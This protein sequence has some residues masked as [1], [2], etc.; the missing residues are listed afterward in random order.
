LWVAL[1]ITTVQLADGVVEITPRG[2]IDAGNANEVRDAVDAALA[3]YHPGQVQLNL[4]LVTLLDSAGIGA[5]VASHGAAA[6]QGAVFVV[7]N[8]SRLIL[9]Q[10]RV[11]GIAA[12]VGA[13]TGKSPG[14]GIAGNGGL[15][16]DGHR[17]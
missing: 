1:S 8:P 2:E 11:S 6:L 10:L 5:L 16:R 7:T 17:P 3:G 15:D 14:G 4:W 9:R 12:L 13:S